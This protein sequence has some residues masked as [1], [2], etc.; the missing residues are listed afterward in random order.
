MK[1]NPAINIVYVHQYL[2][3]QCRCWVITL[4]CSKSCRQVSGNFSAFSIK[5]VQI[6]Q[7]S[8]TLHVKTEERVVLEDVFADLVGQV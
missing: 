4:K 8:A 1:I 5:I 2:N 6:I 3:G 7:I